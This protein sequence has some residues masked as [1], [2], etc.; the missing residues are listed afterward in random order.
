V[1]DSSIALVAR[2]DDAGM[3]HPVYVTEE[4]QAAHLPGQAPGVET[5]RRDEQRRMFM[6]PALPDVVRDRDIDLLKYTDVP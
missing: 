1:N 6:D 5:Q 4:M 2:A 3:C